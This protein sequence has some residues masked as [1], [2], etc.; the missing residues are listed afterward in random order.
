MIVKMLKWG[1][2]LAIRIPKTMADEMKAGNGA[3]LNMAMKEDA[4]VIEPVRD[5]PW[6]LTVLL[7]AVTD[8]NRHEEWEAGDPQGREIW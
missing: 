5:K 6:S 1:N 3:S 7:A 8:K 4:L 2:S